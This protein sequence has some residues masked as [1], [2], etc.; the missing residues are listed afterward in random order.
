MH[1]KDDSKL[2]EFEHKIHYK[3][4]DKK[5]LIA[6]LTHSSYKDENNIPAFER[7]EFLGDS[8]L[9]LIVADM[10][11][12]KYPMNQEGKLSE[13]KSKLVSRKM[14]ALKGKELE[15][16]DYL[17]LGE[18]AKRQ[19]GKISPTI[20]GNAVESI[21]AAIYLDG[22]IKEASNF[23]TNF[24]LNDFENMLT[25]TFLENY[26]SILQEYVQAKYNKLPLYKVVSQEGPP[27]KKIFTVSVF[28]NEKKLAIA[29]GESKKKAQQA[30]AKKVCEKLNLTKER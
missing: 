30:A 16:A 9:G 21:I 1:S 11:F 12:T 13:K 29:K 23:I 3:F 27:H 14:L 24:I 26:K 10:L 22:G 15:L 4:K 20:V 28:I 25:D 17:Y 8:V 7:L 19:N 18:Q 2:V 6:S 5:L